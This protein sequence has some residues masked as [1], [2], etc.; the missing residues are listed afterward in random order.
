M[1]GLDATRNNRFPRKGM[2]PHDLARD[3]DLDFELGSCR[4]GRI[5]RVNR[6]FLVPIGK[7]R[8]FPIRFG[9]MVRPN[10]DIELI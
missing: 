6:I 5:D 8:E 1:A 2:I 4:V 7:V 3:L 9:G 10:G